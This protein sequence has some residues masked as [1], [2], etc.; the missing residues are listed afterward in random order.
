[1]VRA[2]VAMDTKVGTY[3]GRVAVHTT[4]RFHMIT[5]AG[6][7]QGIDARYCRTLQYRDGFKYA[8]GGGDFLPFP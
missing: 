4:S 3:I 2:E 1:M 5:R 8:K 6:T 7:I